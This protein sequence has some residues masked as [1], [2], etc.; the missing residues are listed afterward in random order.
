M[1]GISGGSSFDIGGEMPRLP[2]K[3]SD[4][5]LNL[6]IKTNLASV[7]INLL[8]TTKVGEILPV[9]AQSIDGPVV[10][11]KDGK[12]LG[13]VLSSYLMDLLNC[14]N[15]DTE[16]QAEIIKIDEAVC[17]VTISAVK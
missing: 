1:S 15:N 2:K 3:D 4:Y 16:Y 7:N 6:I 11:M 14:I 17:Q 12:V 8:K 13:T 10:V 9:V 5:C